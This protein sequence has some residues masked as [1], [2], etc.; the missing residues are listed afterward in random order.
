MNSFVLFSFLVTFACGWLNVE[1]MLQYAPFLVTHQTGNITRIALAVTEGDFLL[2]WSLIGVIVAF[3]IGSALAG[4]IN[5]KGD[6]NFTNA[7][8]IF[9]IILSGAL[10]LFALFAGGG[11][12]FILY[13]AF[14]SGYQ[15]GFMT[16]FK[17]RVSHLSGISSDAGIELGRFFKV[18]KR[19]N[20]RNKKTS[21]KA[22]SW[23]FGFK[24]I[25]LGAFVGGAIVGA[26]LTGVMPF[27]VVLAILS[28]F[29]IAIAFVYFKAAS[30]LRA[31][32]ARRER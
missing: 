18:L 16:Q 9:Y 22:L 24:M 10:F 3:I 11:Y 15:N 31:E 19:R 25:S 14:L 7:F 6:M 29:N 4:F 23:S 17:I 12:I 21:L 13:G 27:I 1:F 30:L 2:L 20:D 28:A 26:I 32:F 5:P 8:G